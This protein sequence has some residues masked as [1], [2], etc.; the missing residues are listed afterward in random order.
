MTRLWFAHEKGHSL[1]RIQEFRRQESEA[2]RKMM[3]MSSSD[4]ITTTFCIQ[5]SDS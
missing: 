5:N 2:R 3:S 1:W 4:F